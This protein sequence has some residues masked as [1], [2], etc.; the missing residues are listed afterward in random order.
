MARP[1]GDRH[2]GPARREPRAPSGGS[3][4]LLPYYVAGAAILLAVVIFVVTR[5]KPELPPPPPPR[6]PVAEKPP[7]PDEPRRAEA[8]RWLVETFLDE[9]RRD[10]KL[11]GGKIDKHFEEGKKL[12]YDKIPGFDWEGERKKIYTRLLE[13]EPD[14]PEANR[15]HGLVPLVDYPGFFETFTKL[16]DAKALPPEM[17]KLRR[18]YEDRVQLTPRRTAPAVKPDEFQRVSAV[19]DAFKELDQRYASDPSYKAIA[20]AL[21]R[22][23]IDP[24][25][26]QYE[27]VHVEM[28]PF[29]L[30]YGSREL[31]AGKSDV[32][33]RLKTR[34]ESFRRLIDDLLAFHRERWMGPLGLPDFQPGTVFL[35]W[36]FGD[37]ESWEHYGR[38]GGELTMVPPGTKGY[39]STRDH[40]AFVY[41]DPKERMGV[42]VAV[43]H[44][45]THLLHWYYS[46]DA[47]SE[48][49]NHFDRVGAVWFSEGWAE[50]VGAVAKKGDGYVFGQ[51]SAL[52]MEGY[53]LFKK[54]ELPLYPLQEF[55]KRENY[56]DWNREVL[57]WLGKKIQLPEE[58][59]RILA[60]REA[61]F[62]ML[63][64]QAWL[65]MKFLYDGEGGKY[66][67]KTLKFTKATLGGYMGFTGER[68]YAR[69][70]EVFG[71]IF[72]LKTKGDWTR[73]QAEFDRFLE[74]KL[75]SI[76]PIR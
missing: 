72:E 57:A 31:K 19:L 28:R 37:K 49:K 58:P 40:W 55:V 70:H 4:A 62:G 30:F 44:E 73:F 71:E 15:A 20:E 27:F 69:A 50:Y 5:K 18:D 68:G 75:Y 1:R 56:R 52:R 74:E 6:N 39:F 67:D 16:G 22:V 32:A 8:R 66:R 35:V 14:H 9:M 53:Q 54:L 60:L 42:D 63:Y 36:V 45:L 2:R 65:F 13:R 34:L 61:Y 23:K 12:G 3:K 7:D 48:F 59:I 47:Q 29:V 46:E 17:V 76:Q 21:A 25:L 33:A 24:I 38:Q 64:S 43:A 41:D 26:G 51:D 11:P 10:K